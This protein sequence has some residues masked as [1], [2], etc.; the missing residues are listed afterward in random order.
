MGT[1]LRFNEET[2][3]VNLEPSVK[4]KRKDRSTEPP[5]ITKKRLENQLKRQKLRE[6]GLKKFPFERPKHDVTP[7]INVSPEREREIIHAIIEEVFGGSQIMTAIDNNGYPRRRFYNIIDNPDYAE[8]KKSLQL[9]KQ[10]LADHSVREMEKLKEMLLLN[11]IDAQTYR[12][13]S[14][15]C[16]W[17]AAKYLPKVYGDKQQI[18]VNQNTQVNVQH[19]TQDILK[20]NQMLNPQ[21]EYQPQD[22]EFEIIE[23]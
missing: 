1:I 6:E 17:M 16:K 21:L 18:D 19:S 20:L 8:E 9:A 5:G 2:T 15:D 23:D 7:K 10:M 12:V 11:Q 4:F 22:A 14:D 3:K 13:L